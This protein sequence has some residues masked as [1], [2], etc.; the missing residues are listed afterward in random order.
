MFCVPSKQS[1]FGAQMNS[2]RLIHTFSVYLDRC[3][4]G[5]MKGLG[6]SGVI[7][8]YLMVFLVFFEVVA[9]EW[10]NVGATYAVEFTIYCGAFTC[11]FG[12]AY[13]QSLN[14]HITINMLT[15]RLP[16]QV[17]HWLQLLTTGATL[18]IIGVFAYWGT[19]MV[20]MEFKAG[21]R[22]VTPLQP[23]LGVV[24]LVMVVGFYLIMLVLLVQV[25][26]C[27]TKIRKTVKKNMVPGDK[28]S[29]S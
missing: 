4:R 12:A 19:V 9:R 24:H 5:F 11:F 21:S 25:I 2:K 10:L 13:T 17:Q 28:A 6:A 22:A 27:V 29:L 15:S 23:P 8:V 7:V 26:Q 18:V 20:K 16:L 1:M 3:W 14:K